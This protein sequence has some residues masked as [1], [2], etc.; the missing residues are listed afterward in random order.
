MQ[1]GFEIT[2]I[3][4]GTGTRLVV[5]GELD[6]ASAPAFLAHL[7]GASAGLGDQ[8]V[9]DLREVAFI[10]STGLRALLTAYEICGERLA[11]IPG[12]ACDRLFDVAGVREYLP[13]VDA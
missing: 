2:V 1:Q 9:L 6:V 5:T 10:D 12:P 13:L 3:R 7:D 11:I 4:N 8:L